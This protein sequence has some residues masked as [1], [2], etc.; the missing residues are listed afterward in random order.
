[1][2]FSKSPHGKDKLCNLKLYLISLDLENVQSKNWSGFQLKDA[3]NTPDMKR[4]K[5]PRCGNMPGIPFLSGTTLLIAK[6]RRNRC[7][8]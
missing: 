7:R 8:M 1:M 3:K 2:F 5:N 6:V 4:D